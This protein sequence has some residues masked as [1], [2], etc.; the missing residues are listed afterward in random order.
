MT[1]A[2]NVVL[3]VCKLVMEQC[4]TDLTWDIILLVKFEANLIFPLYILNSDIQ[5]FGGD[6]GM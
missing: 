2:E 1:Y 6:D 4:H 3:A 5:R